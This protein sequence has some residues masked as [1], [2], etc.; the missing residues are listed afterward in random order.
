MGIDVLCVGAA[1]V[2]ITARPVGSS[3]KWKEKQRISS[4]QIQPGGD[5]VN[6]SLR[7]ADMGVSVAL[8]ACIG[9]DSNGRLLKHTLEERNVNTGYMAVKDGISTGTALVLVDEQG[10]RHIFSVKGA[11]SLIGKQELNACFPIDLAKL[12]AVSLASLFSMPEAEKDG[13]EDFL[14]RLKANSVDVFADL[15]ADKNKQGL[16][17]VRRFLPYI[18]YFLPSLYDALEMTGTWDAESAAQ[19]YRSLGVKNVIIKCGAEGCYFCAEEK[20]GWIPAA[21]VSP[22]DTTGAGDCMAAFFIGRIL[23]GD[24]IGTACRYACAGA[25]YSTLF[26][27]A[28]AKVL[29]N[30]EI[31]D[32]IKKH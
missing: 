19:V 16:D 25:S 3:E 26:P 23:K 7:L 28:S 31:E 20:S 10:E 24:D 4:I 14:K 1:V 17:G 6:Q 15:A 12:K 22:V 32:W 27:G 13:L 30:Q 9:A 21:K 29:K 11:H 5:A 18:D 2:D 8:A